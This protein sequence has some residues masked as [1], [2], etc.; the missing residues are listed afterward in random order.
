[1]KIQSDQESK[2]KEDEKETRQ[3]LEDLTENYTSEVDMSKVV[4][5]EL[6]RLREREEEVRLTHIEEKTNLGKETVKNQSEKDKLSTRVHDISLALKEAEAK[7]RHTEEQSEVAAATAEAV[8]LRSLK[9]QETCH[10]LI[11]ATLMEKAARTDEELE[12]VR[13]L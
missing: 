12:H 2:S 7:I 5:D 10:E 6:L 8:R 11:K 4:R 13:N 3:K 9:E 1:M